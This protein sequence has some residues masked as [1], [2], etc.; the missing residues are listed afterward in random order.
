VVTNSY[1][2]IEAG[3]IVFTAHPDDRPTPDL[4]VG[5]AHPN[6][7]LRVDGT[8]SDASGGVLQMRCPAL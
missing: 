3:P 6:V 2:T 1:G 5:V 8:N 7:R 4:S